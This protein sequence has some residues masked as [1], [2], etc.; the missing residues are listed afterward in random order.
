MSIDLAIEIIKEAKRIETFEIM[1]K[2]TKERKLRK[3]EILKNTVLLEID[4]VY[5]APEDEQD[6][7]GDENKEFGEYM[8]NKFS[9][10]GEDVYWVC[11]M[12]PSK[13]LRV[14]N[15]TKHPQMLKTIENDICL[16]TNDEKENF[17][18]RVSM[19]LLVRFQ[20]PCP[21]NEGTSDHMCFRDATLTFFYDKDTP[22]STILNDGIEIVK[23]IETV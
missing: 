4:Y 22:I 2:E 1:E 10:C 12:P 16:I 6:E 21:E 3:E 13:E 8:Y 9:R 17:K 20:S 23:T 7:D 11:C 14:I 5:D 15:I 18:K 19:A